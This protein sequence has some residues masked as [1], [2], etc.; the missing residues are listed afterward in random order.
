MSLKRNRAAAVTNC[1]TAQC[2]WL[3]L[4][5]GY[6]H[7]LVVGSIPCPKTPQ[8]WFHPPIKGNPRYAAEAE[9]CH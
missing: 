2:S 6:K 5:R 7:D 4:L 9:L 1:A 8:L 3:L